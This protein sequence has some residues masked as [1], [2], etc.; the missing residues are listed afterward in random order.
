MEFIIIW[1]IGWLIWMIGYYTN[2]VYIERDTC[3]RKR[4]ILWRAFVSGIVSWG[5]IITVIALVIT[6][7]ASE[8]NDWIEKKLS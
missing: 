6:Y 8:L 5:G 4:L 2:K 1:I 7:Y 3:T